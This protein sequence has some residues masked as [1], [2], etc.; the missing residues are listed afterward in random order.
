MS[1]MSISN[2]IARSRAMMPI[3]QSGL[4]S[5]NDNVPLTQPC[6]KF[7]MKVITAF[8]EDVFF[9]KYNE[10]DAPRRIH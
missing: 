7:K 1:V 8:P 2:N 4:H 3:C 10:I 5:E 9:K 6:A